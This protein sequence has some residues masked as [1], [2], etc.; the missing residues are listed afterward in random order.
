MT[1]RSASGGDGQSPRLNYPVSWQNVNQIF[2][3]PTWVFRIPRRQCQQGEVCRAAVH[4]PC[5]KE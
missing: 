4:F 3:K 1:F 5:P 2:G